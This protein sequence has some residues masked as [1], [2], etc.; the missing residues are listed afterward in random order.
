METKNSKAAPTP[1]HRHSS[2]CSDLQPKP[3]SRIHHHPFT[4]HDSIPLTQSTTTYISMAKPRRSLPPEIILKII[5][6]LP[7][8]DGRDI[9]NL[10]E[11]PYLKNLIEAYEHSITSWFMS[12]E[13]R[14]A[15]VDFPY[16]S[17]LSLNWLAECVSSYDMVD[18]IMLELTWRENCV[19]VESHNTA[20][21]N[22]GLLLLYQFARRRKFLPISLHKC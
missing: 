6:W 18:A 4:N 7:F 5:Q 15:Q 11:I 3:S 20:A 19:A 10:R 22:A 21:A 8:Q 17:R 1:D 9:A 12:R 16:C 13:L 2:C 14:H